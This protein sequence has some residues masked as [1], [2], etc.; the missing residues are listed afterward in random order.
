L[1]AKLLPSVSLAQDLFIG[2][3]PLRPN[4]NVSK[5]PHIPMGGLG[6]GSHL[7]SLRCHSLANIP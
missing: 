5:A 6:I 7:S 2:D 3:A 4:V 1:S